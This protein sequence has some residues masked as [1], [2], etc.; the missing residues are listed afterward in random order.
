NAYLLDEEGNPEAFAGLIVAAM[1]TLMLVDRDPDLTPLV[2]FASLALAPNALEIIDQ[3]AKE[4]NKGV[5][6][7]DGSAT[8]AM[9]ELTK[10]ITDLYPK[11]EGKAK[12][13]TPLSRLL[14]N[15]VLAD[16]SGQSPLEEFIDSSAEV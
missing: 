3:G 8:M 9:L 7:I 11:P 16:K 12:D 5:P 15:G 2:Q 4:E 1:D 10:R 6:N 13:E 14:K